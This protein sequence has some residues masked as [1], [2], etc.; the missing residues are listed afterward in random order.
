MPGDQSPRGGLRV[1]LVAFILA[2]ATMVGL[3]AWIAHSSWQRTGELRER[4][5]SVQIESFK[6]A[7]H[8]QREILDLN[9]MVLRFGMY[10]D[11]GDLEH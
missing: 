3:I 6:I 4:L 7:D 10:H 2:I 9:N 11:P 1:R 8:I 5:T